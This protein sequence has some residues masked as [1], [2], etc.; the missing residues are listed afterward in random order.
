MTGAARGADTPRREPA[1]H[2]FGILQRR[3]V[4]WGRDLGDRAGGVEV[5]IPRGLISHPRGV[6]EGGPGE[7]PSPTE[8][9]EDS[10]VKLK[11]PV[12]LLRP[13]S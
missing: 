10:E 4:R 5:V 3:P 11:E 1:C 6:G 13:R 7:V 12:G 9:S 2:G 8:P